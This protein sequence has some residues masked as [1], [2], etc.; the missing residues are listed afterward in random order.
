[1]KLLT[2]VI[3]SYNTEKFI[4]KNI[5]TFLDERLH[6]KIEILIINDGSKD[7]TAV[8]AAAY[9]K[10]YPGYIRL[11]DKENGGHGSV[12]NKSIKEAQG[13]YLKVVDADDWVNTENLVHLVSDLAK[14]DVDVVLNP[15]ISIDEQTHLERLHNIKGQE[16]GLMVIPF[17]YVLENQIGLQLHTLTY[18]TEILKNHDIQF[19]E[20]CFYEDF[21][22]DI[23][24]VPYIRNAVILNYPV[25]WYLIGQPT[26]SVSNKNVL[27]NVDMYIKV[28]GDTITYFNAVRPRLD[29]KYEDYMVDRICIFLRSFYN[30][31]LRNFTQEN[32][33]EI[34]QLKDGRIRDISPEFYSLVGKKYI[35]IKLIRANNHLIFRVVAWLFSIYKKRYI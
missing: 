31:F 17:E 11:I 27:R 6:N 26:Q 4:D 5:Q 35:Y 9:E 28:F 3:P 1:M 18:R 24:P 32:I 30:I 33:H 16:K 20:K 34:M 19:T 15:Y 23:F 2:I 8:I 12:I 29:K 22:Y 14:I 10:Q 25:V 21:Q 7:N 13:K